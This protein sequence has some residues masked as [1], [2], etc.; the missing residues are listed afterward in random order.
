MPKKIIQYIQII[1]QFTMLAV[2]ILYDK[3][4]FSNIEHALY[5][6]EKTKILFK[7]Y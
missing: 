2:Y 3:E 5:Y 6:L 1:L 7:H 4:M